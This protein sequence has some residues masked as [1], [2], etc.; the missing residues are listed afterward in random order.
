MPTDGGEILLIAKNKFICEQ[1]SISEGSELV[2]IKIQTHKY[3]LIVAACYRPPKYSKEQSKVLS[4]E[5]TGLINKNKKWPIWIG[6]DFNLPDINWETRSVISHQY[7]KYTNDKFLEV[8]D[9]CY[10]EQLVTFPN[11][12]SNTLVFCWQLDQHF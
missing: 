12:A 6:G 4:E 2:A 10:L 1:I 11:R 9:D 5:I 8:I 3:P 7:S